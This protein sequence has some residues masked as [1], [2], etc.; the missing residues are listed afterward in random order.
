[1]TRTCVRP[2]R[3]RA[4]LSLGIVWLV[5]LAGC[6]ASPLYRSGTSGGTVHTLRG[7]GGESLEGIASFYA[8]KFHGRKTANGETYDMHDLTAA[9]R[10]LP[11]GTVV[12]VTNLKNEKTV[13]VRINDRGPFVKNRIIDLSYA[14]A[15]KLDMVRSGTARVRLEV[16]QKGP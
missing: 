10:T 16:L 13:Q 12:R 4:E 8:T 11:F 5:F 3:R 7:G 14:A 15:Q 2:L 1:M 6:A 9:H